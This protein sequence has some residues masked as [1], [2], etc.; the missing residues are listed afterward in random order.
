MVLYIYTCHICD[1]MRQKSS[2]DAT[3]LIVVHYLLLAYS[4]P[5]GVI[6]LPWETHLKE[7]NFH[8]PEVIKW[9]YFFIREMVLYLFF[10]SRMGQVRHMVCWWSRIRLE[11]WGLRGE[12]R[13]ISDLLASLAC[14]SFRS[15]W[16]VWWRQGIDNRMSEEEG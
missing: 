8:L 11:H 5:I 14:L 7:K 1:I 12:G 16:N 9:R 6:F 13:C 2:I 10:I 3:E 4:I 15:L